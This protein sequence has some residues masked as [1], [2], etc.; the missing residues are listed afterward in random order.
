M[1]WEVIVRSDISPRFGGASMKCTC[2]AC[3]KGGKIALYTTCSCNQLV[4]YL[5]YLLELLVV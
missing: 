3:L 2:V 4:S 5:C 1:A